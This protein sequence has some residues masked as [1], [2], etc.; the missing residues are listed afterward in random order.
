MVLRKR[1]AVLLAAVMMLAMA[2]PAFGAPGGQGKGF[3]QG[4]GGGDTVHVDNGNHFAKG[5]GR[6]NNPHVSGG[7]PCETC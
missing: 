1:L 2:S 4:T 6:A 3:G 5:G 7:A